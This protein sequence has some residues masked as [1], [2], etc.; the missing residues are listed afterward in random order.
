MIQIRGLAVCTSGLGQTGRTAERQNGSQTP[1]PPFAC[2]ARATSWPQ[3]WRAGVG[4]PDLTQDRGGGRAEDSHARCTTN[5]R[6]ISDQNLPTTGWPILS[7]RDCDDLLLAPWSPGSRRRPCSF[8]ACMILPEAELLATSK[9]MPATRSS[10]QFTSADKSNPGLGCVCSSAGL[11]QP[12]GFPVQGSSRHA[13]PYAAGCIR[14]DQTAAM[15]PDLPNAALP[16]PTPD[17]TTY[18]VH[19]W[20]TSSLTQPTRLS[21]KDSDR[22]FG[23]VCGTLSRTNNNHGI[24]EGSQAMPPAHQA[25]PKKDQSVRSAGPSTTP[26]TCF[27]TDAVVL[28]QSCC[29]FCSCTPSLTRSLYRCTL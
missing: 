2:Q 18:H 16:L 7:A 4:R 28:F 27:R 23:P 1:P 10:L 3:R 14:C 6:C 21:G 12:A 22:A 5:A 9:R 15:T 13:F 19:S 11:Q 17:S 25:D 20:F 26:A 8:P 24:I 29:F